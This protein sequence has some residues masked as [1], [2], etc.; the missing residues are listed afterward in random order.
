MALFRSRQST[1]TIETLYGVIVAQARSPFFFTEIGIP[2][3]VEGRFD[4]IVLHL[5]LVLRRLRGAAGKLPPFGQALFDRFCTDMDHNLREMGVG[6]MAVPRR[7]RGFG[8]AF[9][10]R[11]AAYDAALDADDLKALEAALERNAR[12]AEGRA[13]ALA[14]YARAAARTL[15]ETSDRALQAGELAFPSPVTV[16]DHV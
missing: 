11:S 12:P 16:A 3:T 10:G 2:D 4:M 7:M 13:G 5:A 8:E 15:A 9:Y 14:S 1:N 6:E